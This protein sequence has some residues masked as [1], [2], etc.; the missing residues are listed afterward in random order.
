M[1][2]KMENSVATNIVINT[3]SN[4]DFNEI[5]SLKDAAYVNPY[6]GKHVGIARNDINPKVFIFETPIV[7]VTNGL[8]TYDDG[9][10][11]N[12]FTSLS[13]ENDDFIELI[14]CF[15]QTICEKLV[16]CSERLLSKRI[17]MEPETLRKSEIFTNL[18]KY[19]VKY[20][21]SI[22]VKI[23]TVDE[24]IQTVNVFNTDNEKTV[25]ES[26]ST[27]KTLVPNKSKIRMILMCSAVWS[28]SG[29]YG[30]TY[31]LKQIKIES[32]DDTGIDFNMSMFS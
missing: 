17:Q 8:T 24:K 6:G 4:V 23:K 31:T 19:S 29:R 14:N 12:M 27:L 9:K 22:N 25:C 20:P 21:P 30:I 13:D 11:Y 5:V 16:N 26:I 3:S 1:V 10:T 15:E 7:T 2:M 18:V 32:L 28:A